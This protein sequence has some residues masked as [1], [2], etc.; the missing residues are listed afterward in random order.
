MRLPKEKKAPT[1][2]QRKREQCA[3]NIQVFLQISKYFENIF[4]KPFH[5]ELV[6]WTLCTENS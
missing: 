1:R 5:L 3:T 2:I 6:A 4:L